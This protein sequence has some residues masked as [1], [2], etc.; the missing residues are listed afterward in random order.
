VSGGL[1]PPLQ[2]NR[3]ESPFGQILAGLLAAHR[4]IESAAFVDG[5]G[6]CVDYASRLDPFE[7]E[8]AGAQMQNVTVRIADMDKVC[9]GALVLWTV[10]AARRD[11]VVRRVTEEH[12]V[13]LALAAHGVTAHLLRSLPALADALRREGQLHVPSWDLR[14]EV[15]HVNVRPSVGFGYAP[16]AV[17]LGDG[18]PTP[19]EVLGRW[20]ERGFISAEEVICFR[21]RCQGRE[22]TLTHDRSL[23]RWHRR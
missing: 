23:D 13:V 12:C 21:V 15:F 6:E 11:F 20:T 7:A 17:A 19:V 14:G 10:E 1:G 5:L 9:R 8:V 22:L 2:R 3:P 4:Q 18:V 16:E